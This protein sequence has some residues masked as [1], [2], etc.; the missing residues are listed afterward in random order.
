MRISKALA[1]GV[2]VLAF[3]VGSSSTA[4]AEVQLTIQ[5]GRVSLV[6]KD[7]TLR[8]IL[9]E[10]AKVG[11]TK[12]VNGERVPGGP[13]TLRFTDWPEE[14]VLDTL[15]RTLTGYVAQPRATDVANLS[16]FDRIVVMPTIATPAAAVSGA[17][18]PVFP[19]PG[20][21]AFQQQPAQ[22]IDD[23]GDDERPLPNRG[24]MFNT[25][26]PPQIAN[27]APQNGAVPGG[28]VNPAQG[29]LML[30]QPNAPA[31]TPQPGAAQHGPYPTGVSVPGMIVPAPQQPGQPPGQPPQPKRPG[32]GR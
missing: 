6:A 9:A 12:I 11:Q 2:F 23:Q 4:S 1:L 22:T 19:Q 28:M 18:A 26:P 7:A 14:R 20:A 13:L 25:F 29:P 5:N 32:G 10:W 16:R 8:Q 21:P 3:G 24:P 30:P 27:P 31:A 15:L 17:P